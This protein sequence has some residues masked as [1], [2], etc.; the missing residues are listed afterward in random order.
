M[1]PSRS[2]ND[3]HIYKNTHNTQNH[4][5]MCILYTHRFYVYKNQILYNMMVDQESW[6]GEKA[7]KKTALFGSQ[8]LVSEF[9]FPILTSVY[10]APGSPSEITHL[11][12]FLCSFAAL[13]WQ[14][15]TKS[16]HRITQVETRNAH[17]T[18]DSISHQRTDMSKENL[19]CHSQS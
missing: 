12:V 3:M 16:R 1:I 2:K 15:S 6:R 18:K 5:Y 4:I 19:S 7:T 9:L 13:R 11:K 17:I 10:W 14:H 8:F